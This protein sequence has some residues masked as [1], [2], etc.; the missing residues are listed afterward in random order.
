MKQF[1]LIALIICIAGCDEFSPLRIITDSASSNP[2]FESISVGN[3]PEDM[4]DYMTEQSCI[5]AY[6]SQSFNET[7]CI[8]VKKDTIIS[9]VDHDTLKSVI[10][11][12]KI[13]NL[14]D[15]LVDF[16]T[17]A[18]LSDADEYVGMCFYNI[19]GY[20]VVWV[21]IPT[22]DDDFYLVKWNY[23]TLDT[24]SEHFAHS[25]K[26]YARIALTYTGV[27]QYHD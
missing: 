19:N 16:N 6:T 5:R 21:I 26:S 14:N 23:G 8:Q 13:R 20:A 10:E 2:D 9:W 27:W 12:C 15:Q 17:R 24:E 18:K 3:L 4:P 11:F 7:C 1:F 25:I 22:D